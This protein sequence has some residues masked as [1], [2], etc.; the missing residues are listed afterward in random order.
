MYG[1][2]NKR[3]TFVKSLR[4]GIIG[5]VQGVQM[6]DKTDSARSAV[7]PQICKGGDSPVSVSFLVFLGWNYL[8]YTDSFPSRNKAPDTGSQTLKILF[9]FLFF[10]RKP[11]PWRNLWE[12]EEK[13]ISFLG[14]EIVVIGNIW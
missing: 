11:P 2:F 6:S 1:E 9:F 14:G 5:R 13:E 4:G 12:T 7:V 8:N 3:A 10:G